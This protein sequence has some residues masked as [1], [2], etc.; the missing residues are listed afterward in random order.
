MTCDQVYYLAEKLALL[1]HLVMGAVAGESWLGCP[2]QMTRLV[3]LAYFMAMQSR[4]PATYSGPRHFEQNCARARLPV[5]VALD[6][7]AE[8]LPRSNWSQTASLLHLI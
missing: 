5:A 3:D 4:L 1:I 7:L 8:Y 2:H 6:A